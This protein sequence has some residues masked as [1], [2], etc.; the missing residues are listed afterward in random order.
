MAVEDAALPADFAPALAP[1]LDAARFVFVAPAFA[2]PAV[3]LAPDF[4][5]VAVRLPALL[6]LVV[7][8]FAP[9]RAADAVR[10]A[11]GLE[12]EDRFGAGML[13]S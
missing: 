7:V 12:V 8:A 11:A 3:L 1:R 5:C 4:A 10:F 13:G 2:L 6:A 9:L